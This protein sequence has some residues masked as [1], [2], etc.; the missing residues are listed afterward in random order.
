MSLIRTRLKA[1]ESKL[2][3]VVGLPVLVLDYLS[4]EIDVCNITMYRME[5]ESRQ[6]FCDRVQ[7]YYDQ[8]VGV[9]LTVTI[10]PAEQYDNDE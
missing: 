1:L 5:N 2:N 8:Q 7:D 3:P 6:A 9:G 4:D 10:Y